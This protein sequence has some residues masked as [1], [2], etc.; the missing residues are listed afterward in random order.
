MVAR[1][2]LLVFLAKG[3]INHN[4]PH[5]PVFCKSIIPNK[6]KVL[7]FDRLLQVL[8]LRD[9]GARRGRGLNGLD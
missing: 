1:S 2:I 4:T 7:C 9:L 8:I 6:V 3:L 5:P